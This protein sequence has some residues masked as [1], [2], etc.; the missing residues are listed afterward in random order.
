MILVFPVEIKSYGKISSDRWFDKKERFIGKH[1]FY[2]FNGN[3]IKKR[4]MRPIKKEQTTLI[5]YFPFLQINVLTTEEIQPHRGCGPIGAVGREVLGTGEPV[6]VFMPMT[7]LS[8]PI[9]LGIVLAGCV[10]VSIADSFSAE[11]VRIRLRISKARA[12]FTVSHIRRG[13][14]VLPVYDRAADAARRWGPRR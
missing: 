7:A 3:Q 1:F 11:Q 14:K 13:D 5:K 10:V 2:L 8:V 6:A 4:N 12:V 9:Y